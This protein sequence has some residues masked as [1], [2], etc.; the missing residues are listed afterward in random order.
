MESYYEINV[1]RKNQTINPRWKHF[2][3]TA[4]RSIKCLS[5]LHRVLPEMLRA[6]P[7]PEFEVTL[8]FWEGKGHDI[9]IHEVLGDLDQVQKIKEE[10]K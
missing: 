6:F 3:A 10:I 5:D 9:D 4:P 7:P 8:T 1:A 2:F